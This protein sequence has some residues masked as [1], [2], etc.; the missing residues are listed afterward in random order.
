MSALEENSDNVSVIS[1]DEEKRLASLNR[2]RRIRD[3]TAPK[4][5]FK[6]K[7]KIDEPAHGRYKGSSPYQAAS[8]ALTEIAGKMLENGEDPFTD[9]KFW[10]I[11]TTYGSKKKVHQYIG[12]REKL[13]KEK[14][15]KYYVDGNVIVKKYNNVF[16]KLLKTE[17]EPLPPKP[18][19]ASRKV[20]ETEEGEVTEEA[21]PPKKPKKVSAKKATKKVSAKKVSAKKVPAKKVPAKK[22]AK[23]APAKKVSTKA[24]S[25][26]V[27]AK[28]PKKAPSKKVSAK[29]TAK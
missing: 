17:E 10:L 8:K 3:L 5:C 15:S 4:K 23:K 27:T 11:E 13:P 20:V 26:K 14:R 24:P 9:F 6:A 19:R 7:Y 21:L 2:P 22:V 25:K 18:K 16:R 12:H 1:I 28:A 29:K